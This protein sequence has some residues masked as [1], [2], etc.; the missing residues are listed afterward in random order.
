LATEILARREQEL[1]LHPELNAPLFIWEPVPDLCIP[2][3][4]ERCYEALKLVDIVSPNHQELASF[5]GKATD[6][7][8]HGKLDLALIERMCKSW[9][10]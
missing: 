6:V 3:E 9:L 10:D 8:A 2:E 1:S 4:L 5:L 7:V